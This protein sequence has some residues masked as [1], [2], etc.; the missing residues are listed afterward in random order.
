M[1]LGGFGV[2][3]FEVGGGI[4]PQA[5][6]YHA[7]RDAVGIGGAAKSPDTIED[8]WRRAKAIGIASGES[9]VYRA[10]WQNWPHTSTDRVPNWEELLG[11]LPGFGLE[12]EARREE[13]VSRYAR[14]IR[15]DAPG[16][17]DQL[18]AIDSRLS[19]LVID[20]DETATTQPGRA[21]EDFAAAEPF[22]GGR[23]ATDFPN[24]SG[25]YFVYVFFDM[26]GGALTAEH[27]RTIRLVQDL[28]N[29]V[30]PAWDT[31]TI[32]TSTGFI[33]DTSPVDHSGV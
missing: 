9:W 19:A 16:L 3:P 4:G 31:W 18:A 26:G 20:H 12:D 29:D 8:L 10:L 11:A 7:L 15:A 17:N 22:G 6:V 32:V 13:L 1:E 28:L 33:V 27:R 5:K 30:L 2:L 25:D 24:F 14:K 21:F 23:K